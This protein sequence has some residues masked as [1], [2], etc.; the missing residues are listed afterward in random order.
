MERPRVI[1][2]HFQSNVTEYCAMQESAMNLLSENLH[3]NTVSGAGTARLYLPR[4][5]LDMACLGTRDT[6]KTIL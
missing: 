5:Y 6:S 2:K 3:S 1:N 4:Y